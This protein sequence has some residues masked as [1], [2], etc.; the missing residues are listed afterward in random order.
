MF[1]LGTQIRAPKVIFLSY[2]WSLFFHI[3]FIL[4]YM[5]G[6]GPLSIPQS[7]KEMLTRTDA[8]TEVEGGGSITATSGESVCTKDQIL[9]QATTA[10]VSKPRGGG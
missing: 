10:T 9:K 5:P 1:G 4:L 6:L 2:S 3:I 7:L 8:E